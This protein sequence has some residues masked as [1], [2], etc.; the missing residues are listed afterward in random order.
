MIRA[1]LSMAGVLVLTSVCVAD[2]PTPADKLVKAALTK[3][4][5]GKVKVMILFGQDGCP[6]CKKAE[7]FLSDEA[8]KL[9]LAK[10]FV[11]VRLKF[12]AIKGTKKAYQRYVKKEDRGKV[13]A[14]AVLDA[15]GK[16]LVSHS[17][18]PT[19]MKQVD[20]FVALLKSAGAK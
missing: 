8:A 2:A 1:A 13:P 9:V 7:Q 14:W 6:Y 3:A 10:A 5:A 16:V 19:D 15:E 18:F 12:R 20:H 17:G 11:V 4:R